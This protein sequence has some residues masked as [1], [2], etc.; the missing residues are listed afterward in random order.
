MYI[1]KSSPPKAFI[2]PPTTPSKILSA[3]PEK[4]HGNIF[5]S[6]PKTVF[7][8]LNLNGREKRMKNQQS[9]RRI[10]SNKISEDVHSANLFPAKYSI[11]FK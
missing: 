2:K 3:L 4:Y 1:L 7:H 8:V 6:L 10:N 11:S 9:G 5:T